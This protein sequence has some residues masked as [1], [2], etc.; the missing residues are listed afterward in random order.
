[1]SEGAFDPK[2]EARL[3]AWVDVSVAPQLQRGLVAELII[4]PELEAAL[5]I[6]NYRIPGRSLR[7]GFCAAGN[8]AQA[9]GEHQI[10]PP[11]DGKLKVSSQCKLR[12]AKGL[13]RNPRFLIIGKAAG[14]V[15]KPDYIKVREDLELALALLQKSI[16]FHTELADPSLRAEGPVRSAPYFKKRTWLR[17]VP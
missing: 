10:L 14:F 9:A 12:A 11:W 8:Q 13:A 17:V 4:H 5:G 6:G 15:L 3:V 7:A 1:M 16:P 2:G